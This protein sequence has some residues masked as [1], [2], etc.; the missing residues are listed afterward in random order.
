MPI[1]ILWPPKTFVYFY[2][3]KFANWSTLS[4]SETLLLQI[5]RFSK[6]KES[7]SLTHDVVEIIIFTEFN[8]FERYLVKGS[9]LTDS[10]IPVA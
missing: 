6:I 8:L 4:F 10:L 3:N 7:V 5:A 9:E 2:L 1:Y